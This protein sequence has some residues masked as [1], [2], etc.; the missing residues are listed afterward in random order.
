MARGR[1][2]A[3]QPSL[4]STSPRPPSTGGDRNKQQGARALYGDNEVDV[5]VLI[6]TYCVSCSMYHQYCSIATNTRLIAVTE[7]LI[8]LR[9]CPCRSQP[10]QAP[11]PKPI[12]AEYSPAEARPALFSQPT[13]TLHLQEHEVVALWQW[14]PSLAHLPTC[15][16]SGTTTTRVDA[17]R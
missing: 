2:P 13:S 1:A 11:R 14:L 4:T 10:Q 5:L 6:T 15:R 8:V 9:S 16:Q 7:T 12:F 17:Q 3:I